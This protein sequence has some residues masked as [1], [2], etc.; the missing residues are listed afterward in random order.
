MSTIYFNEEV[1]V[2]S[3]VDD[4]REFGEKTKVAIN[5]L[6]EHPTRF[7]APIAGVA[8]G[9]I[10]R[11]RAKKLALAKGL[12]PGTK[13]Y[14]KF[15]A[16]QIGKGVLIGAAIG[17]TGSELTKA[18]IG[19]HKLRKGEGENKMKFGAATKAYLKNRKSNFIKPFQKKSN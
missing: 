15:M 12:T 6:K 4:Q 8:G 16:K 2:F 11:H 19:I 5:Y 13:E 14:K 17:A 7:V 3:V 9:V 1:R 10:Q 18:G